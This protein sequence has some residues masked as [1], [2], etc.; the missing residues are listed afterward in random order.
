MVG[1]RERSVS[2]LRCRPYFGTPQNMEKTLPL[3][4]RDGSVEVLYYTNLLA[5]TTGG[6]KAQTLLNS[7]FCSQPPLTLPL[8]VGGFSFQ[9]VGACRY[10][11]HTSDYM[12]PCCGRKIQTMVEE[13]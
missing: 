10:F 5:L 8:A 3:K 9:W 7:A 4:R 6:V 1:V 11:R 13:K 2:A 12:R